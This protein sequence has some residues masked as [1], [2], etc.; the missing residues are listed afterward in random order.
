LVRNNLATYVLDQDGRGRSGYDNSRIVERVA[1]LTGNLTADPTTTIPSLGRIT[2]NASYTAWFGHLVQPG[3]AM[4]CL[5]ITTCELQP[6]GWS[7]DD[8]SPTNV[9]PSPAGYLPASALPPKGVLEF[10]EPANL[11]KTGTGT[12]GPTAR[13]S[14]TADAFK[15]HFYR[16]LIP[17]S[18]I[19]LPTSICPTCTP[20]VKSAADTWSP[21]DVAS[22]RT[23]PSSFPIGV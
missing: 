13:A 18:E 16:Q 14:S 7:A 19:V 22:L 12:W 10:I 2:D 15:L 9:H 8:P 1:A 20:V 23:E 5:D 17:N 4:T 6:H 11:D 21:R 3:T